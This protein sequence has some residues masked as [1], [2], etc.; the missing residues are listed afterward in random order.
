MGGMNT[1]HIGATYWKLNATTKTEKGEPLKPVWIR[2][3]K[4][5]GE[6]KGVEEVNTIFG[7]IVGIEYYTYLYKGE[8]KHAVKIKIKD[9]TG[10]TDNISCGFN[11]VTYNILNTMAGSDL[12]KEFQMKL[13]VREKDDDR[14]ASVSI[15]VG[16]EKGTWMY[17]PED[18]PKAKNV[19]VGNKTYKDD[20]LVIEFWRDVIM[21]QLMPK[22]TAETIAQNEFMQNDNSVYRMGQDDH[23]TPS[24]DD[25]PF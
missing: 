10:A 14:F 19:P 21:Q 22:L 24:V 6:W 7:T 4:V 9:S 8:T 12:S 16:G 5:G 20:S 23:E 13:W 3:G 17:K 18:Q 11:N 15:T 25:L 2:Q 1:E